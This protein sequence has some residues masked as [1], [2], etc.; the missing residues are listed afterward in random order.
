MLVKREVVTVK[1][2][3]LLLFSILLGIVVGI[4]WAAARPLLPPADA[5]LVGDVVFARVGG[6]ELRLDLVIPNGEIGKPHPTVVWIHGG[7]WRKG[8]RKLNQAAWLAGHGYVVASIEYR[9]TGEAVFPAQIQ[10][11]KAAIRFL[12]ANSKAYGID[13]QHVAVWGGSAGGH[14]AALM[15]TTAGAKSL[16]GDSG[17]PRESSDVQAVIDYYGPTDLTVARGIEGS[18]VKMITDLL[19]GTV[20]DKLDLAKLASPA[21]QVTP[22]SAPTLIAHGE[23]DLL[24]PISQGERFYE[25]LRKNGVEAECIRVKNAGHGFSGARISPD[26]EQLRA[27]VLAFLDRHLK[28]MDTKPAK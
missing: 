7:G 27:R 12:R 22:K 21:L 6:R 26:A 2:K 28:P 24:V 9:L 17:N 15:G 4:A 5:K 16:E 18:A 8:T 14:L 13:P 1:H 23:D 10:D 19:G 3:R 11:C 20:N 25:A